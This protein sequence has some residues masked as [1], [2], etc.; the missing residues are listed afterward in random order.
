MRALIT[1][2]TGFVG[3]HLAE[4][5]LSQGVEVYGLK[6]WRSNTSLIDHLD[7]KLLECDMDDTFSVIKALRMVD[8][9][10][11]YHLAAQS[12][13][14]ASYANPIETLRTNVVTTGNLFE[15]VKKYCPDRKILFASSSEVYGQ[16]LEGETPITEGN[17]LRPASPYAVSKAACDL[18]AQN[19]NKS[20]GMNIVITR[21]FTHTGP[22]RGEV[23]CES[24]FARQIAQMELG[25][26]DHVSHGNL[27]SIRTWLD[28]R[29]IVRLFFSALKTCDSGVYV[30][31]GDDTRSVAEMLDYLFSI[32][33][34]EKKCVQDASR[35]RPSDVTL[36]VPDSSKIR[37]ITG[38]S[39]KISFEKTMTDLLNFWR[40]IEANKS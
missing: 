37:N 20:Y 8:P 28:A 22:G 27:N 25:K 34:V 6:R 15:A 32:S 17:A 36:Q 39:P 18:L 13:V 31:G 19:Y 14:D 29:D 4:Y 3:S 11:I 12:Y 2:V 30:V 16:V 33:K 40:K 38:W 35:F 21:S 7:V 26:R 9:D 24:S 10:H 5:L 23:F 1:G